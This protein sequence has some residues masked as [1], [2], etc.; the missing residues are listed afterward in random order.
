MLHNSLR[1]LLR[2]LP[3]QSRFMV[4]QD[5]FDVGKFLRFIRLDLQ[6]GVLAIVQ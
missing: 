2:A 3:F 1:K 6:E 4:A 5:V